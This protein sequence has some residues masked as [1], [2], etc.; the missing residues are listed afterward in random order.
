MLT[1]RERECGQWWGEDD[2]T[3]LVV[4]LSSF[5]LFIFLCSSLSLTPGQTTSL[6]SMCGRV[7]QLKIA[8]SKQYY[9]TIDGNNLL[10]FVKYIKYFLFCFFTMK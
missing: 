4:F 8:F 6:P 7:S 10:M 5:F 2:R 9:C 3:P 1:K